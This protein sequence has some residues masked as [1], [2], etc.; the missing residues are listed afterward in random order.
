MLII[1]KEYAIPVT[2]PMLL[3]SIYPHLNLGTVT[4]GRTLTLSPI[5][6]G[7]GGTTLEE[8]PSNST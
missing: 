3:W 4:D 5:L 1:E 6:I 7:G 8:K 2:T